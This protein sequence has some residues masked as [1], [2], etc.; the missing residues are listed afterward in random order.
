MK[1]ARWLALTV[2]AGAL[3]S[4]A[5]PAQA[6]APSND[7]PSGGTAI[8]S[9]PFTTQEDTTGATPESGV[10]PSYCGESNSVWFKFSPGNAGDAVAETRGSTFDTVLAVYEGTWFAPNRF[11]SDCN[12]DAAL[13]RSSLQFHVTPFRT[14][15]IKVGGFL[16]ATGHL[17]LNVNVGGTL[18]GVLRDQ[19]TAPLTGQCV[20]VQDAT[21]RWYHGMSS[22]TGLYSINSLPAGEYT[23]PYTCAGGGIHPWTT[24]ALVG[25]GL[26]THR[27]IVTDRAVIRGVVTDEQTGGRVDGICVDALNPSSPWDGAEVTS[28]YT[29][30]TGFYQLITP[31]GS[32]DVRFHD[33]YGRHTTH[34]IY[35]PEFYNGAPD[36]ASA[37]HVSVT[38]GTTANGI[39]ASLQRSGIVA[40][41]VTDLSTT[42][43]VESCVSVV[44]ASDGTELA[45]G[46]NFGSPTGFYRVWGFAAQPVQVHA[47]DCSYPASHASQ[48]YFASPTRDGATTVSLSRGVTAN[49]NFALGAGSRIN[50]VVSRDGGGTLAYECVEAVT[51]GGVV[52]Q[53]WTTSTGYYSLAGLDAGGYKVHYGG[54]TDRAPEW[55]QNKNDFASANTVTVLAKTIQTANA[56]LGAPGVLKASAIDPATSKR[57]AV[58][59]YAQSADGYSYGNGQPSVTGA[60]SITPLGSTLYTVI[61]SQCGDRLAGDYQNLGQFNVVA[62]QTTNLG[63]LALHMR[64]AD[65]DGVTDR[66]DNCPLTP[67][68]NQADVNADDLGDACDLA[69]PGGAVKPPKLSVADNSAAEGNKTHSVAVKIKMSAA[70]SSDVTVVV[71]TA[72]GSAH[73]GSDY[74]AFNQTITIP[75]G[76]TVY[77]VQ[78]TVNGDHV[79][80]PD[81][82]FTVNL[83]SPANATI[84]RGTATITLTNDD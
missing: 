73:A 17:V 54:C 65:G 9:L 20:S 34:G 13:Q 18:A 55:Y 3:F 84:N 46:D 81:E 19:S 67:N 2:L 7:N 23:A 74:V 43:P 6:T 61:A 80:E 11:S 72:D 21:G 8:N 64:D 68:A 56:S 12:D 71:K 5:S 33:C 47:V 14:Y 42:A 76:T 52:R 66:A 1:L 26:T 41:V 69:A 49:A 75:A 10:D 60:V 57:A 30:S 16:G 31:P 27:D 4:V 15:W 53:A 79:V 48:W 29:T 39:D 28:M 25:T 22:V 77:T 32:F 83:S 70:S 35:A 44:R 51:D 36:A 58:C 24:P 63:T 50:G 62:G 82:T 45:S 40:G 78:V 59:V 37:T 38:A